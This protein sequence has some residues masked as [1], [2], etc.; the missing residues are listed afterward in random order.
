MVRS[1]HLIVRSCMLVSK[2][3]TNTANL[4][5]VSETFRGSE[6]I[7][8][9]PG[10]NSLGAF[11]LG[12]D[13][14]IYIAQSGSNS[15][16]V[17]DDPNVMGVGSNLQS[18]AIGL[19]PNS[20]GL[21]LPAFFPDFFLADF[22]FSGICFGD[23]TSFE[24]ELN[25][26]PDSILWNFDD[27]ASGMDSTSTDI[28]A[29]HLF[30]GPDTFSVTLIVY[31][32]GMSDTFSQD[33]IIH[34]YIDFDLGP[35]TILCPGE[36]VTLGSNLPEGSYM[37]Q[38]GSTNQL[39][40]VDSEGIYTVTLNP[41][42]CPTS[43]SLEVSYSISP[44]PDLGPDT[45]LCDVDFLLLTP[46][47]FEAYVWQDGSTEPVFTVT[48]AGEYHVEVV[49]SNG[50]FGSDTIL[51]D[52]FCCT[53]PLVSYDLEDCLASPGETAIYAEF[54]PEYQC[55]PVCAG[56]SSS[57]LYRE[58]GDAY[59]HSCTPGIENGVA[60]CVSSYDDCENEYGHP[61][62]LIFE[63]TISP[64]SGVV[65]ISG[66][67]FYEKAPM[68][69]DWINGDSG[70]NDFPTLYS[71][72]I[73][74]DGISIFEL[75]DISTTLD[76]TLE[77]FDFS[78]DPNFTFDVESV[79]RV[80]LLSYCRIDN[81]A[82]VS[83]WDLDR[84][85]LYGDCVSNENIAG[86]VIGEFETTKH[87]YMAES[88]VLLLDS[89][90]NMVQLG[91]TTSE[92]KYSFENIRFGQEYTIKP[93]SYNDYLNGVTTYDIVQIQKHLLGIKYFDAPYQ[94]IAADMDQSSAV[95][96]ADLVTLRKL[97]LGKYEHIPNVDSWVFVRANQELNESNFGEYESEIRLD[98]FA[99]NLNKQDFIGVKMGDINSSHSLSGLRENESRGIGKMQYEID[100]NWVH[101]SLRGDQVMGFQFELIKS[102]KVLGIKSESLT[103][104]NINE[105]SDELRVIWADA[106]N[107]ENIIEFSIEFDRPQSAVR[108]TQRAIDAELYEEGKV[109]SLDFVPRYQS[110]QKPAFEIRPNPA[111]DLAIFD[112]IVEEESKIHLVVFDARGNEMKSV[113]GLY[114]EGEHQI[115]MNMTDLT[116]GFYFATLNIG[117]RVVHRRFLVY[118]D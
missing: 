113:E 97:L 114:T 104:S 27:P 10:A 18:N 85:E 111:G 105:E 93:I 80:E 17:I 102:G 56:I 84:I 73:L 63:T 61:A 39:Y 72:R 41:A 67:S 77:E 6:Q 71:I 45:S 7:F 12:P 46:G 9:I 78:G 8:N 112:I 44:Q 68:M 64:E 118:R 54:N 26:A 60:I 35:D 96:A 83:A 25:E 99:V 53:D 42:L 115:K 76:W 90:D 16:S 2:A 4:T 106:S 86:Y 47:D 62:S 117:P 70:P 95:T 40:T 13:Q 74:R 20:S 33:V 75:E 3:P 21:G 43:D 52:S 24:I 57:I 116:S 69:F 107:D 48:M 29:V 59:R 19:S 87:E 82:N 22:S 32:D 28:E 92:G 14:K 11:Q 110:G 1:F 91:S 66:L 34:P 88:S 94:Y 38:D 51:I 49:D 58:P 30:T 37:W 55:N 5:L 101:F 31:L 65:E 108:V 98:P 81:G 109:T 89:E 100:E 50:C 36:E 103:E 23:S 15:L 79:L